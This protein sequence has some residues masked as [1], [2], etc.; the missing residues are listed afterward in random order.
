MHGVV[1]GHERMRSPASL[2]PHSPSCTKRSDEGPPKPAHTPKTF[3]S[4]NANLHHTG[5][6]APPVPPGGGCDALY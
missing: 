4:L 5:V 3:L 1:G 6:C 2:G